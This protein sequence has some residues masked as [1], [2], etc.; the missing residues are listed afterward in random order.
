MKGG[1]PERGTELKIKPLLPGIRQFSGEKIQWY[2]ASE[3][4]DRIRNSGIRVKVVDRH[5]RKQYEVQP[6]EFSGR[7]LHQ[8]PIPRT[9]LGEIYLEPYL[10]E[11]GPENR[12][13]LYR[14]G[15]R[16]LHSLTELEAFQS[17]PWNEGYLEGI[18]DV[19]FLNLTPGTRTGIIQDHAYAEFCAAM[20]PVGKALQKLIEEQRK[21]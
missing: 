2:L 18:V 3:L 20:G 9:R 8:L 6:R 21:A 4:R 19:P 17:P 13:G 16:V 10:G 5:A 12:I 15:T 7:L 14:S 1:W 11:P